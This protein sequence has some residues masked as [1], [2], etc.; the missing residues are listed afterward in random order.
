MFVFR[1]P[2]T[3]DDDAADDVATADVDEDEAGLSCENADDVGSDGVRGLG[4][5]RGHIIASPNKKTTTSTTT[6]TNI[7]TNTRIMSRRSAANIVETQDSVV[8]AVDVG[9]AVG[10][11]DVGTVDGLGVG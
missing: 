5:K 3:D 1:R 6:T 11:L 10:V 4:G 8:G 2:N 9:T 7:R